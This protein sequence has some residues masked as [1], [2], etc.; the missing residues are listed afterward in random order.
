M[1]MIYATETP[2]DAL[3]SVDVAQRLS[4]IV[5]AALPWLEGISGAQA[6]QP[7]APGK[8]SAK[9]VLGHLIDSAVNNL[10][11]IVRL[12]TAAG[13][14]I[15]SLGYEQEAW[16]DAQRYAD[17]DWVTLVELWRVLNEHIAWTIRH[18]SRHNLDRVCVFPASRMSFGF[19]LEDYV[20]HM[21]HH[22]AA[23]RPIG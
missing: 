11:R 3:D 1:E 16:V 9:Q 13:G 7:P 18:V 20:A 6:S 12:E 22:L 23:L 2:L 15:L 4:E 19:L 5:A 10:Q 14:E 8:W 21:E 17:R